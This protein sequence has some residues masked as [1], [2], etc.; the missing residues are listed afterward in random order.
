MSW[1]LPGRPLDLRTEYIRG[2]PGSGYWVEG[3][4]RLKGLPR[5]SGF[6]HRAQVVVRVEQFFV[7]GAGHKEHLEGAEEEEAEHGE[8]EHHG[9]VPEADT[10]RVWLG[11]NYYLRDGLKLSFAYGRNFSG[12][13]DHNLWSLG[14]AYRFAF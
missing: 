11:W 8:E 3:A 7:P 2:A 9:A 10:Q 5:W 13:G 4:Y 1:P 14:I 6:F 12:E